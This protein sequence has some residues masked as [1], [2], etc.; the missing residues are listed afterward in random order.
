MIFSEDAAEQ[1]GLTAQQH[2]A[3]LAI[4]G[5]GRDKPMTIGDA[6]GAARHPPP[7][8]G[9]ADRP[10]AIEIA[11]EAAHRRGG[12]AAGAAGADAEGRGAAR[13]ALCGAPRRAASVWRRCC[14]R[15]SRISS[16]RRKPHRHAAVSP[17]REHGRASG[18]RSGAGF[19]GMNWTVAARAPRLGP[20]RCRD[21]RRPSPPLR[22]EGKEALDRHL[23]ADLDH[24]AGR[25]LE[26]VGGVV[27]RRARAR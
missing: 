18:Q 9:R 27:G 19:A 20:H 2:Q 22:G 25:D 15:C 1:A 11:G 14:R 12:P 13:A 8:R 3:L 4:K 6:R 16:R 26:I 5:F 24:A 7:Q 17:P 10:S 23:R 21:A